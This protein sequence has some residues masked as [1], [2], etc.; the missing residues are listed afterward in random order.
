MPVTATQRADEFAA[1][2]DGTVALLQRLVHAG[3]VRRIW[4]KDERGRTLIE[5]PSTPIWAAVGAL[6]R[7]AGKLTIVVQR[8]EA[9]PPYED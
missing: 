9:W 2:G 3:N 8:E 4:I 1:G 7:M 6:A 5:I